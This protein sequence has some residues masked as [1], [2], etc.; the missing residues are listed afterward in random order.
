[1]LSFESPVVTL[2]HGVPFVWKFIT[3]CLCSVV[4][5]V[6]DSI[7]LQL[8]AL[9]VCALFYGVGGWAFFKSGLQRLRFLWLIVLVIVAWH[10][11]SGDMQQGL[12]ISLRLITI[13]ALSNLMTMTSQLSDFIAVI[14]SV[15]TPFRALGINTRPAE[16]AVALVVRFTPVLTDKGTALVGAWRMRSVKRASWRLVFPLSL[17]AMDDAERVAEALKA[18]G[19]TLNNNE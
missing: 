18:R 2:W 3:V 13:V 5:F 4:L 8:T 17:V 7:S 1:M 12:S 9:F 14:K 11:L 16:I 6:F 10:A 19:G 15:L